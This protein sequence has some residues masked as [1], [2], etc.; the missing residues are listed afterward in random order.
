M[1]EHLHLHKDP[2]QISD[3]VIGLCLQSLDVISKQEAGRPESKFTCLSWK[4]AV[5]A[6]PRENQ[7]KWK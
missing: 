5:R 2:G 1:K 4:S 7:R 6:N 3:I